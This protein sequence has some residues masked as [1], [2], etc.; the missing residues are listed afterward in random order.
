MALRVVVSSFGMAKYS[1]E[2]LKNGNLILYM[3]NPFFQ[4]IRG[5]CA[6][7]FRRTAPHVSV[8]PEKYAKAGTKK[9]FPLA[10]RALTR[11]IMYRRGIKARQEGTQ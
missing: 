4:G 2:S 5:G 6:R 7:F 3:R 8:F 9:L 11:Y 1:P 10:K